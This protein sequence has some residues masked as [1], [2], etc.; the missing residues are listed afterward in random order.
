MA[1][2]WKRNLKNNK[3]AYFFIYVGKYLVWRPLYRSARHLSINLR[4]TT[5]CYS[6]NG[7]RII[8]LKNCKEG[9]SCVILG[10]GPSVRMEDLS[11]IEKSGVD[12]FGANRIID[13]FNKTEWRPTYMCVCD[14]SFLTGVNNTTTCDEYIDSIESFGIKYLF[15]ADYLKHYFKKESNALYYVDFYENAGYSANPH[16]FSEDAGVCVSELGTVTN[17]S[18]QLAVYMGYKKIYLYGMD[19]TYTRYFGDDGKFH[20]NNNVQS[21]VEGMKKNEIDEKADM[22]PKSKFQA[23]YIGGFG[24]VRKANI[25]YRMCREYAESHGIEIINITRGGHLEAF[26]REAFDRVFKQ[27]K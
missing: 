1:S 21:H 6:T 5:H 22:V 4:T 2:D 7:K 14:S 24:D 13:I 19:N 9:E 25:G 10:N 27:V 8:P 26:D 16:P 12:S 17:F 18:I 20:I 11:A 3:V 23:H 15:V